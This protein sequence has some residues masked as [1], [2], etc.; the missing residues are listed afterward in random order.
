[1]ETNKMKLRQLRDFGEIISDTFTF[2]R[3]NIGPLG[4]LF[5]YVVAPIALLSSFIGAYSQYLMMDSMM[6]L[7]EDQ[8]VF[9]DNP[10]AAFEQFSSPI[11][12][13]NLF[14]SYIAYATLTIVIMNYMRLYDESPTGEVAFKDVLSGFLP[15]LLPVILGFIGVTFITT[16][17]MILLIIPGVYF[18]IASSLLFPVFF[19]EKTNIF[20][21]IK[22]SMYLISG[23]WWMSFGVFFVL[24]VVL[25]M[26]IYFF[27]TLTGLFT[28]FTNSLELVQNPSLYGVITSITTFI[29]FFFYGII[30]VATGV[31]YFSL[32]EKKEG[33][34]I[35]DK[36]DQIG[37][38]D[39]DLGKIGF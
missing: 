11:F 8:D 34:A 38:S 27:S 26:M 10:F 13:L 2:I 19:I 9:V 30:F 31:L 14:L 15:K 22:R 18:A 21:A 7:L 5:L 20:N 32:V 17:G 28:G 25:M 24:F 35:L 16:I 23:N 36:I 29:S 1:M 39:E 37:M 4:K 3:E 33:K 12:F 6:G